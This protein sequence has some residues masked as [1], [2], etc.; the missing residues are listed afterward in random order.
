MVGVGNQG[1]V[2]DT[3]NSSQPSMK[4]MRTKTVVMVFK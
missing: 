1:Q 4:A 3:M 2:A